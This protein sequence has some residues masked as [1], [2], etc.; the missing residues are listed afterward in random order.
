MDQSKIPR[1]EIESFQQANYQGPLLQVESYRP[2]A[3]HFSLHNRKN[4]PVN[5]YISP[6]RRQFYKLM[7][8]TG[9]TGTL[10]IGLHQYSLGP[11]MIAFIH[12][13]DIISWQQSNGDNSGGHFCLIHP[14]YFEN[15]AHLLQLFRSYPYFQAAKAV[16][17]L[18]ATQ[19]EKINQYFEA[20]LLEQEGPNEDKKQA[21]FLQ[22][23]LIFLEA[24]RAGKV[25]ADVAIPESYRYI[26]DFLA[27]LES[28]ILIQAPDEVVKMKTAAEFAAQLHVHPNYLNSLVKMQTGKTLREHIQERLL[29]EA[30]ALLAHTDWDI[31]TISTALGFSEPANF[32][33]FFQRQ[34]KNAPSLYRASFASM[35]HL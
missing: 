6:N 35:A 18:T 26:H 5:P 14:D 22:L 3:H 29:A 12:P 34:E 28:S 32:T 13:D 30:K 11:G 4:Y 7:H 17:Q 27:L 23:Q 19:S 8:V 33:T 15:T 2:D 24:Q 21:I 20:M 9:G 10:T 1:F 31:Q 25:L 16:I